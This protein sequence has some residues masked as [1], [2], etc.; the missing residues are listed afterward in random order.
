L[1]HGRR[2]IPP[3]SHCRGYRAIGVPGLVRRRRLSEFTPRRRTP[4]PS[5]PRAT[6]APRR[7]SHG[8][9]C[10]ARWPES[11][12]A[13]APRSSAAARLRA[14]PHAGSGNS[15]PWAGATRAL[16]RLAPEVL[17]LA[18]GDPRGEPA[19]RDAGENAVAHFAA[20]GG[21]PL[22]AVFDRPKTIALAWGDDGEALEWNPTFAHP[23]GGQRRGSGGRS[24]GVE[25]LPKSKAVQYRAQR[26]LVHR[27][28]FPEP[29][30]HGGSSSTR[31]HRSG[32]ARRLE[33]AVTAMPR[34]RCRRPPA[35]PRWR[36]RTELTDRARS[37]GEE[38]GIRSSRQRAHR[39]VRAPR[40][41]AGPGHV[42]R[43]HE[44][45]NAHR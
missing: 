22:A 14:P 20:M 11:P 21:V 1:S 3:G 31:E 16:L 35:R 32:V 33:G 44:C 2:G 12:S 10:P 24:P 19:G 45:R 29:T 5:A 28:E 34:R 15:A 13:S 9:F 17:A 4:P 30:P 39:L 38:A 23:G 6:R 41:R 7:R 26:G 40:A 18:R 36:R 37:S 8:C 42:G 27:A 25:S 43:W